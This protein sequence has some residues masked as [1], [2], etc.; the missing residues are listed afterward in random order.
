MLDKKISSDELRR[1]QYKHTQPH[2]ADAS[3]GDEAQI[4]IRVMIIE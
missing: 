1:T 4:G 2:E 3:L